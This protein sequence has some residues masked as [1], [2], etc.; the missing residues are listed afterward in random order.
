MNAMEDIDM[1]SPEIS[2]TM[3]PELTL[4]LKELREF[5]LYDAEGNGY[6][7]GDM[8]AGKK[9]IIIFIRVCLMFTFLGNTLLL[10][11]LV[12]ILCNRRN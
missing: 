6:W 11:L 3:E 9:A 8:H 5:K 4:P 12:L 7:F 10:L 1:T 2:R